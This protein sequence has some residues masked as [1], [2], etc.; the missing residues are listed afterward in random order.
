MNR[1]YVI[2]SETMTGSRSDDSNSSSEGDSGQ[3]E[4]QVPNV[5]AGG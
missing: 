1:S 5:V 3:A 2:G 4:S